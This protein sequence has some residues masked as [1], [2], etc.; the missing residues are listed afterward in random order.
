M[1]K[2]APANVN[3][4]ERAASVLAGTAMLI[5]AYGGKRRIMNTVGGVSLVARGLSGYCPVNSVL[6]RHRMRD[7]TREAL[8]GDRGVFIEDSITVW[9]PAT[10][11][12][13]FWRQL[14][15]LPQV[16]SHLVRVETNGRKSHWVMAGPAGTTFEWD[17]EI[18]NDVK[19]DLIAWRSL[20]GSDI[21]SAGSVSFREGGRRGQ[22]Y[23]DVTVRMQYDAPGGKMARALAWI[24][25]IEPEAVVREE[26]QRFKGR[27]E[28]ETP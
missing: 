3:D 13:K 8:G 9:R 17:A 6:G 27:F 20:P 5:S 10:E 23:T 25:G 2:I 11:L 12:Y 7:D 22:E 16:F 18:I 4:F 14:E 26:L 15:N 1:T 19:P 24:T 28:S 21:A